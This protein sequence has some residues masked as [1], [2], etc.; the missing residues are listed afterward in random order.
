MPQALF[1][2][3]KNFGTEIRNAAVNSLP[4]PT[5]LIVADCDL[6][7]IAIL[8]VMFRFILIS[9]FP[10]IP[11]TYQTKKLHL[12]DFTHTCVIYLFFHFR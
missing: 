9:K 10:S 4:A 11:K 3:H 5:G 12:T 1:K 8:N 7:K 6:L 2:T